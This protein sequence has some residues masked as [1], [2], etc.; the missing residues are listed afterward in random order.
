[1]GSF[2]IRF[3]TTGTGRRVAVKDLI[4]LAGVP[5]TAGCRVLAEQAAPAAVDALCLAG[6]RAAQASGGVRIV[7]KTNLNELAY[8][9]TGL[10]PWFSSPLN[11]ADARRVVGGSSSGS[12]AAVGHREADVAIGSD[13]GGSVRIPAACCGVAGLKTTGG[14]IPLQGVWPLAPSL[15]TV[16]PLAVDVA[17]LVEGMMLLEP[18]FVTG[19]TPAA[20]LGR[21]RLPATEPVD[22]AIDAALA[23]SGLPVQDVSLP[24]WD[25]ARDAG[26]TILVAEAWAADGELARTGGLSPEVA[27]R[28]WP[29]ASLEPSAVA[30]ARG[31]GELWQA[32]VAAVLAR[33]E[34]LAMPTLADLPPHIEDAAKVTTLRH[35]M[36]WN[37]SGAPALSLPVP[38][39]AGTAGAGGVPASLQLVAAPGRED[40]LLATASVIE[41]AL[42]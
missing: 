1:M 40:L 31:T 41:A 20:A 22:R 37:L 8:G 42:A 12:A 19:R 30:A 33:V 24:G 34:V 18:G 21:V 2:I 28:L 14:R 11:P 36:P 25:A 6:I 15:D 3:D 16:G 39:P 29:G 17:G 5:T 27:V 7:G 4:D 9:V 23:A 10:N 35:T 38:V 32:E 26:M 13:T